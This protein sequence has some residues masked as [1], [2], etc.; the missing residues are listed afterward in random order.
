MKEQKSRIKYCEAE[1]NLAKQDYEYLCNRER[2]LVREKK[3]VLEK[4]LRL[5]SEL[6]KLL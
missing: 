1:T 4:L 6:K 5:K 3:R 2:K